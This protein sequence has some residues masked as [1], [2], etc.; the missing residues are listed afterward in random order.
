METVMAGS[1]TSRPRGSV[2]RRN[3]LYLEPG[4][5]NWIRVNGEFL[6][7]PRYAALLEGIEEFGSIRAACRGAG[8]SYRTA[9]N[10]VRQMER[11]LGAPVIT[12]RRGGSEGGG[13]A[14]TPQARLIVAVYRRWRAELLTLSDAAFRRALAEV[15]IREA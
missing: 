6:M 4:T 9:I 8:V 1:R 15:G 13:A 2:R 14:L 5:K 10:R 7:G 12:T 11:V 3:K